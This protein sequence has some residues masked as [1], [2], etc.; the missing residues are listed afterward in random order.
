MLSA[1]SQNTPEPAKLRLLV[2]DDHE[3]VLGGTIDLLKQQYPQAEILT[4]Q[5]GRECVEP[6]KTTDA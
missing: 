3:I 4:A 2:V 5:T 1:M 6:G